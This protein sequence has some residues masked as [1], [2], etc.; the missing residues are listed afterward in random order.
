MSTVKQN[1]PNPEEFPLRPEYLGSAALTSPFVDKDSGS[2]IQMAT[3]QLNQSCVIPNPDVP[4]SL[5][6]F[7][8]QLKH[9]TFGARAPDDCTV[10]AV[11]EKYGSGVGANRIKRHP[12]T[13]VIYISDTTG[14]YGCFHLEAFQSQNER[15]H[16]TFTYPFQLTPKAA[17]LHPGMRLDKGEVLTH[18]PNVKDG[19]W[20]SGLS[21]NVA[22]Y[23]SHPT[24][25]D[26]FE[27][28]DDVVE[29]A[30]PWAYGSRVAEWGRKY[31]P[32]NLYGDENN[33]KPFPDAGDAIRADGLVMALVEYN[34]LFDAITMTAKE[35]MTPDMDN[36]VTYYGKP[37][38][39]VEDVTVHTTTNEGRRTPHT[40]AGMEV[41]AK[42]YHSH[43]ERYYERILEVYQRIKRETRNN[44][45]LSGELTT[46]IDRAYSER[47][48]THAGHLE[49]RKPRSETIHKTW[50]AEAIDEW[51]VEVFYVY[52]MQNGLGGKLSNYHGG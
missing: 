25:E 29:R 15:V 13:T 10:Y 31:F 21:L 26:G 43:I 36:D 7:E 1:L 27:V 44:F 6:G 39:I 33:Y 4:R 32:R 22:Y 20:A 41:Q 51:R 45:H 8:D 40:P 28:A 9:F 37:G 24:I 11:I 16:E 3:T 50:R 14:E 17:N 48:N 42:K 52:P 35:L 2:R 30:S 38:A 23:S 49:D 18:T 47:P 12:L 19:L 46:L 34:E 5:T